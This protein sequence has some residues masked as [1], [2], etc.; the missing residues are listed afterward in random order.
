LAKKVSPDFTAWHSAQYFR[1]EGGTDSGVADF[2]GVPG[3]G[4][5]ADRSGH[6]CADASHELSGACHHA[7]VGFP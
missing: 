6:G 7:S 3:Y 5:E 4:K 1:R 2:V